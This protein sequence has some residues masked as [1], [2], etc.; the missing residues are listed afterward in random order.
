MPMKK[1]LYGASVQGIQNFIFQ[2]SKLK[3]IIG[4]S[5]IVK[6]VCDVLFKDEF[7]KSGE[8]VVNAAGNIKCV[9][10]NEE[11]CR[12][13]VLRFPKRVIESAPGITISQAVVVIEDECADFGKA[14]DQ[15]EG[16]LRE[17]RNKPAKLVGSGL[18]AT[19]RSRTTGLPA[20]HVERDGGEVAFM[21]ECT[22]S[23]RQTLGKNNDVQLEL[24]KEMFGK[25]IRI[26]DIGL[27]MKDLT[28][29]N[30]WIAVIHIDGNG[31]GDVVA[32]I[33][34]DKE[35]LRTF[36]VNL[37]LATKAAA[38]RACGSIID[39]I[40]ERTIYPIRPVLLGGDDLTVICR[41]D[42]AMRFVRQYLEYFEQESRSR[43]NHELSACAGIAYIKSSYPFHYGYTLAETLCGVAKK[44]AKS[45]FIKNANN[46]K[47]PSCVMFHKVQSSFVEDY[48]E[49]ERKE[50][51]P[52]LE[53]FTYKFGPYYYFDS[54]SDRKTIELNRMTIDE[55]TKKVNALAE[56]RNG[57][58][59]T[60]IREW[61][62]LMAKD[63]GIAAQKEKRVKSLLKDTP[64]GNLYSDA[65]ESR[66][67]NDGLSYVPAYDILTLLT[68]ENQVIN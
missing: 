38:R 18:I 51:K 30:D 57:N 14:C 16:K 40:G 19:E 48:G 46:G 7:Q 43:T 54:Q 24:C 67:R 55:L 8:L 58:V 32:K 50:L 26:R 17:Q 60:A 68:V 34:H 56:E 49:I 10:D 42:V 12:D 22:Y 20:T 45:D 36:S 41:A 63:A 29:K 59:K 5:E 4:A 37:D 6:R 35:K 33:G 1:Y 13:A 61:L 66:H 44:D 28:G 15:L 27:D 25:D 21:D 62:T 23:K 3:D 65:I 11:E 52:K 9:Y 39:T 64:Q 53:N 47:I 2:T 31:L